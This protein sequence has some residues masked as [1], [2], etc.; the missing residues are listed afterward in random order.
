MGR[1][2]GKHIVKT[3]ISLKQAEE[4]IKDRFVDL[5]EN[6]PDAKRRVFDSISCDIA[7]DFMSGVIKY[8]LNLSES[9]SKDKF[10]LIQIGIRHMHGEIPDFVRLTNK[11]I[12]YHIATTTEW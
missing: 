12:A 2:P 7:A 1:N 6:S 9:I 3:N 11:L 4:I 10:L 8:K 5:T